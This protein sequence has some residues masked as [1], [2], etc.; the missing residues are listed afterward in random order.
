M[1][2]EVER[3]LFDFGQVLSYLKGNNADSVVW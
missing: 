2:F 1:E 3:R